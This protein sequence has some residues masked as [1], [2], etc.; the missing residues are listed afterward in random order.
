VRTPGVLAPAPAPAPA[1]GAQL[2]LAGW[3]A[4]RRGA[5]L[6][7][8]P[9]MIHLM[10]LPNPDPVEGRPEHGGRDRHFC[11]G[12]ENIDALVSPC[13]PSSQ[14]GPMRCGGGAGAA[15]MR[16]SRGGGPATGMQ[17]QVGRPQRR[18]ATAHPP[19]P[20]P[21]PAP[22][23]A[24]PAGSEAGGGR[25]PL[26]AL[27][28]RSPGRVLQGPRCDVQA[29]AGG[30]AGARAGAQATS[31][32]HATPAHH[33]TYGCADPPSWPSPCRLQL[34][35]GGRAGAMAVKPAP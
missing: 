10:E 23:P 27:H 21:H 9:E 12:V 34:P 24:L 28:E 30:R 14:A 3:P 31:Q 22:A 7:I 19:P 1:A 32:Q 18:A 35:G 17:A 11:I 16:C 13:L 2:T 33:D 5:W 15:A 4:R 20:T 25:H 8:G 29:R 26:H 6:W